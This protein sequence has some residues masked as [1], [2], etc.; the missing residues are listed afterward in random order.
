MGLRHV[1]YEDWQMECCGEPFAVGDEVAWPLLLKDAGTF[2][3]GGRHDQLTKLGGE[4]AEFRDG[5]GGVRVVRDENGLTAALQHEAGTRV[6]T[7]TPPGARTRTQEPDMPRPGDWIRAVGLLCAELHGAGAPETAGRVR[8]VQVLAQEYAE[9][10]PGGPG[11]FEPVPGTREPRPVR[12]CPK[13]FARRDAGPARTAGP[14]GA[15]SSPPSSPWRCPAPTPGSPRACRWISLR[16]IAGALSPPVSGVRCVQ[17]QGGGGRRCDGG[18]SRASA[19]ERG[20]IGNLRQR[21]RCACQTPR[22]R[23]DPTTGPTPCAGP[24]ACP[25]TPPGRRPRGCPRPR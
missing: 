22:P 4:V 5:D 12:K 21:R 3:G 24:A 13:W 1:I 23:A 7:R 8:A 14:A 25:W 20:G 6:G 19:A 17:L 18:P 16:E 11:G 15:W 2:G 9:T 10:A